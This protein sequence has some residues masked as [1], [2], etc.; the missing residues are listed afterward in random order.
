MGILGDFWLKKVKGWRRRRRI[1]RV[2]LGY[3]KGL[4]G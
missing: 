1:G 3:L 4:L 2:L